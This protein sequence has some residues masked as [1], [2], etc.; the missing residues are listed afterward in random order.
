MAKK[1]ETIN[2]KIENNPLKAV[3]AFF[4]SGFALCFIIMQFYYINRIDDIKERYADRIVQEQ[5][6]FQN[7]L[8]NK[9]LEI[10]L[11]E[12]EKYYQK[13]DENSV[14]GKLLERILEYKEMKGGNDEK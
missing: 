14:N 4:G 5:K 10:Q 8:D 9:I 7:N 13:I 3:M 11:Q 12:R 2:D 6:I 1:E